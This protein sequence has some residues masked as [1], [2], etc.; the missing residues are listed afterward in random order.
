[1]VSVLSFNE[2]SNFVAKLRIW[3]RLLTCYKSVVTSRA[4]AYGA[5]GMAMAALQL[6]N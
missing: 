3:V 6:S 1:M 4:A 5:A 2:V